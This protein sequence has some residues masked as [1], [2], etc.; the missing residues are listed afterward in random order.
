M[1]LLFHNGN[2]T[3][4]VVEINLE[5]SLAQSLEEFS[6]INFISIR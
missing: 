2:P 5:E 3:D 6:K 4:Q 1:S